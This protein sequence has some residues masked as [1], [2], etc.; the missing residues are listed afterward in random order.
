MSCDTENNKTYAE[1]KEILRQEFH[2]ITE[3]PSYKNKTYEGDDFRRGLASFE[4]KWFD[5]IYHS[6]DFKRSREPYGQDSF[7]YKIYKWSC[8]DHNFNHSLFRM[9]SLSDT[10]GH[11]VPFEYP[12]FLDG[13]FDVT[14]KFLNAGNREEESKAL[15]TTYEI[16]YV[17]K[18]TDEN[19]KT[20]S[21]YETK[22]KVWLSEENLGEKSWILP[23]YVHAE[24]KNIFKRRTK[25]YWDKYKADLG[26]WL[27]GDILEDAVKEE[28]EAVRL[29]RLAVKKGLVIN[30]ETNK[31]K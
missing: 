11:D 18:E 14:Y 3:H 30:I 5:L 17:R 16:E 25:K 12:E 1:R 28:K 4:D 9:Y 26:K 13:L 10:L 23:F 24:V 21:I 31:S 7:E 22:K 8:W 20:H 27:S 19:G 2:K 29:V 6:S 15:D